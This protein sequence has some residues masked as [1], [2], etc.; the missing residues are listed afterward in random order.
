M[1]I[2]EDFEH[3]YLNNIISLYY[4]LVIMIFQTTIREFNNNQ[5]ILG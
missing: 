1:L 3:P 4:K 2:S 5:I